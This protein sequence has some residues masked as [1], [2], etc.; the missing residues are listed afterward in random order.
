MHFDTVVVGGGPAG[1]SA[2]ARLTQLGH[3]VCVVH[4]SGGSQPPSAQ[5]ISPGMWRVAGRLQLAD[6]IRQGKFLQPELALIHWGE[7]GIQ[8]KLQ[9]S[10]ESGLLV[11]RTRFDTVLLQAAAEA[12]AHVVRSSRLRLHGSYDEGKWKLDVEGDSATK[13]ECDYLIDASG[14]R[15]FLARAGH[16][17]GTCPVSTSPRTV[18]ICGRLETVFP[19][20]TAMVEAVAD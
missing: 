4:N 10:G 16:R 5:S 1:A 17:F 3:S 14:K 12:G 11:D 9:R 8:K 13:I 2:A 15:G 18:A 19:P 20:A 7:S 6:R